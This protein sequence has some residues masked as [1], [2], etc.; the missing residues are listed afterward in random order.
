MIQTIAATYIN[1][2]FKPN[3]PLALKDGTD[4]QLTIQPADEVDDPLDAV[5]GICD[6]GPPISLAERHDEFAYGIPPGKKTS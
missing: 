2:M 3:E 4:V 1:G 5:I 6:D